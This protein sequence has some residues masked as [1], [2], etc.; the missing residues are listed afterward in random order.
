MIRSRENKKKKKKDLFV[1]IKSEKKKFGVRK[2]KE[3][4]NHQ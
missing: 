4:K 2:N 1:N 3:V